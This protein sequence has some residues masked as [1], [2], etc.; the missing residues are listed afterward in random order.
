MGAYLVGAE[1][2]GRHA[3]ATSDYALQTPR[4]ARFLG[5]YGD[6]DDDSWCSSSSSSSDSEEEGYFLGQPIPQPRPQRY[7]YY[8]DELSSPSSALSAPPFGQRTTKSKKKKGHKGKNCI[9][10]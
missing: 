3:H 9:I 2:Y 4:G 8:T 10:S 5:L 7:G 6:D 1:P